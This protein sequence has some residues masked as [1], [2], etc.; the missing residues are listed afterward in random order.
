[1]AGVAQLQQPSPA[2][3]AERHHRGVVYA[4]QSLDRPVEIPHQRALRE[5]GEVPL[6]QRTDLV[7]QRSHRVAM[8]ADVGERDAGDDTAWAHRDVVDVA[9]RLGRSGGDAIDPGQETGQLEES[10]RPLVA[11]PDLRAAEAARGRCEP[12]PAYRHNARVLSST[13]RSAANEDGRVSGAMKC[14]VTGVVPARVR[15]LTLRSIS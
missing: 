4:V 14:R 3:P 13:V 12:G 10:R 5:S 9:A 1:M 7:G 15:E 6:H 11:R 8:A 2:M